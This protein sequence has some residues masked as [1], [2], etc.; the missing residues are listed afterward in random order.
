MADNDTDVLLEDI[1]HQLKT[2]LE[3]QAAMAS[4]PG[5]I[6]EI[7]DRLTTVQDDVKAIKAAV[8]DQSKESTGIHSQ[9]EAQFRNH[10]QRISHLEERAA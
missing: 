7:K 9:Q 3:G 10:D 5:D 6:S 8:T 2:V 4:V 1:N